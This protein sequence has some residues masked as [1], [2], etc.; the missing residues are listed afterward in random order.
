MQWLFPVAVTLHNSEEAAFM[1]SWLAAH[2]N[3]VPL[4]PPPGA[5]WGGLLFLTLAAIAITAFSAKYGKQSV[6]A[7]LLFGYIAAMLMNVFLPH[8]PA[9][10]VFRAY[11]PGAI[12]AVS[13]N[14]PIMSMLCLQA[15]RE[16]WVSGAK[17]AV[18]AA[19]LPMALAGF[20]LVLFTLT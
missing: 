18:Y 8:V 12:S 16:R 3:R 19:L 5:I 10:I 9:T 14:L 13:I 11:T 15:V 17:A 2:R 1:P 6:P 7:Y 20:I 4:H